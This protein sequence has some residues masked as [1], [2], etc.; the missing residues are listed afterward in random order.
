MKDIRRLF[1][2]KQKI[3]LY[4]LLG[5][6]WSLSNIG[7]VKYFGSIFAWFTLAPFL[8]FLK[9]ENFLDGIK[10]SAIF[11]FSAY[12]IHFWWM[13]LPIFNMTTVFGLSP[14]FLPLALLLALMVFFFLSFFCGLNYTLCYLLTKFIASKNRFLFYFIFAVAGTSIDY[15]YPKLWADYLGYSQYHMANIIQTVDLFGISYV[16]LLILMSN[17]AIAYLLESVTDEK[18]NVRAGAFLCILLITVACSALYGSIRY[19]QVNQ[20]IKIAETREIG[21]VQGNLSGID[22]KKKSTREILEI[23]NNLTKTMLEK[24]DHTPDLI[25]WPES[26]IP[27]WF[28]ENQ[29]DFSYV[30]KFPESKLLFGGHSHQK[31]ENGDS[32][33]YNALF[34]LSENAEKLDFYYKNKLLPFVEGSP[35]QWLDFI[36]PLIGFKE[37]SK[38]EGGKI[39]STN[40][41]KMSTNICYE[42]IIPDYIRTSIHSKGETANLIVNCTNDS[43]FGKTIEPEMHLRISSIRA[44]EN[45]RFL[46]RST[47]TGYSAVITA[48]G[49]ILYRSRL[50]QPETHISKV[51][52]LEIRSFYTNGGW[53]FIYLLSAF[54]FLYVVGLAFYRFFDYTLVQKVIKRETYEMKLKDTWLK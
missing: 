11:G 43:W 4:V 32:N 27:I 3:L 6:V 38:G 19:E 33:N 39:L 48:N 13:I 15:F 53:L 51:A 31:T 14:L 21:I 8:F 28:D 40:G 12:L 26:S 34:L 9:E 18:F 37:F 52:L 24:S 41:I 25:V 36:M 35:F 1:H 2:K 5:I 49:N 16:T 44:I 42:A 22:K 29:K 45:R 20:M 17:S 10:Y 23:Y 7:Y 54:L 47:C 30:K 46:V 50:Y